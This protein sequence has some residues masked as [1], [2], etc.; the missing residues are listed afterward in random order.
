MSLSC[1]VP[2]CKTHCV[3][4]DQ[5]PSDVSLSPKLSFKMSCSFSLYPGSVCLKYPRTAVYL[6]GLM[7]LVLCGPVV[8]LEVSVLLIVG[9]ILS[10]MNKRYHSSNGPASSSVFEE[11]PQRSDQETIGVCHAASSVECME[12]G[13]LST[14][15]P[16]AS[17]KGGNT[18]SGTEVAWSDQ[19]YFESES[20][21]PPP[22]FPSPQPVCFTP[23]WSCES[24]PTS[25]DHLVSSEQTSK[26]CIR[27]QRY[28]K[29]SIDTQMST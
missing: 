19:G 7:S 17:I 24:R 16:I 13:I 1:P 27:N 9:R 15:L 5:F 23:P 8:A 28:S 3:N 2:H 4:R 26:A 18:R 25:L 6:L 11:G 21:R 22:P 29:K 20:T 14:R 10:R 12:S